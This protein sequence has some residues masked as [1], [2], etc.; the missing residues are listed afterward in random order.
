[1]NTKNI[2]FAATTGAVALLL[3]ACGSSTG[4]DSVRPE[5]TAAPAEVQD[6]A[7]AP[8]YVDT[9]AGVNQH[10]LDNYGITESAELCD[11]YAAAGADL[12]YDPL[13]ERMAAEAGVTYDDEKAGD[14][15]VFDA[16]TDWCTN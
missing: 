13:I 11:E 12:N 6:P 9:Y 7:E 1:M 3:G 15:A 5:P 4:G 16:L 14:D 10:L 8:D 2:R